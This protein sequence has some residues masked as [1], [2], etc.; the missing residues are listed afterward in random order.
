MKAS[1]AAAATLLMASLIAKNF[2]PMSLEHKLCTA[3]LSLLWQNTQSSWS[4]VFLVLDEEASMLV[5]PRFLLSAAMLCYVLPPRISSE[6]EPD[7]LY[8]TETG[9]TFYGRCVWCHQKMSVLSLCLEY[10]NS[11]RF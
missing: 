10:Q 8:G 11:D 5:L 2:S 3:V 7:Y 9:N 6:L 4:N 1:R